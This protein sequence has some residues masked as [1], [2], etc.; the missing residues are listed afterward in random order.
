MWRWASLD[1]DG[2]ALLLERSE[3]TALAAEVF[4][5]GGDVGVHAVLLFDEFSGLGVDDLTLVIEALGL[6]AGVFN[7][8]LGLF[9]A[10]EAGT[11]FAATL[12]GQGG[13][14]SDALLQRAALFGEGGG[15]L[16]I[17]GEGHFGLGERGRGGCRDA[18]G[19]C[20]GR[21]RVSVTKS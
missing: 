13:E 20:R 4:L 7:L 5:A 15:K 18:G 3:P 12:L 10:L 9:L 19:A 16:L 21:H 14:F 17:G 11:D 1:I 6:A 8:G 2:A